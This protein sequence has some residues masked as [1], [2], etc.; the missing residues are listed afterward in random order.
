MTALEQQMKNSQKVRINTNICS[1]KSKKIYLGVLYNQRALAEITEMIRKS[2]IIHQALLNFPQELNDAES[3]NYGNKIA[4]LSGDY[5]LCKSYHELAC[6]RNQEVNEHIASALRNLTECEFFGLHDSQNKPLPTKPTKTNQYLPL[7]E[8]DNLEFGTEPLDTTN[9]LGNAYAEWLF[10][11]TL[12][13]ANLLGKS[14]QSA[15]MLAGHPKPKQDHGYRFGKHLALA[16]QAYMDKNLFLNT[17]L[18]TFSLVSAPV[19]FHLEYDPATYSKIEAGLENVEKVD[20]ND[21]RR[22]VISGPGLDKTTE[23]Q[24]QHAKIANEMLNFFPPGEAKDA[25]YNVMEA[26]N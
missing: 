12:A 21:L 23:I 4:L 15:F 1:T 8:Q 26:F 16:W 7:E 5:L 6:L 14:C 17:Q 2:I 3:M 24:K 10:R 25:L 9:V 20:Y 22:T 13:G 11:S 19:L 18:Q